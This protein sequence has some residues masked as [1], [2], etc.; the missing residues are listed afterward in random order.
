MKN[1]RANTAARRAASKRNGAQS[2]GPATLQGKFRSQTANFKH[3]LYATNN[4]RLPG[5]SV[6]EYRELQNQFLSFWMPAHPYIAGLVE[7][8]VGVQWELRRL[9]AAKHDHVLSTLGEVTQANP[10]ITDQG[11]LN[12]EAEKLASAEGGTVAKANARINALHRER[13][14]L[15]I[16]LIRLEKRPCTSGRSQMSLIINNRQ[17]SSVP[18]SED[19]KPVPGVQSEHP[20]ITEAPAEPLP[21]TLGPPVPEQTT[22]EP[23]PEPAADIV[24]WASTELNIQPD[25]VQAQIMTEQNTRVMVLAPRQTGKSTAAAV[26]VIYEAVHHHDAAI[27]IASASGRQSGQIMEKARRMAHILDLELLPPPSKCD[28]FSLANGAQVIALPDNPETIRGFSAPRLI[29]VDEA[30]FASEEL[31]KSLEPMLTVSNGT[32]ML[33]ST[34]NGQS[35]YF[36]DQWHTAASPWTRIFGTLKDCPRVNHDAIANIRKTMSEADFQQEFECKFVAASGQFISNELFE[37]C[38]RDDVEIFNMDF[39]GELI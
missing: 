19:A 35:G 6:E 34:P 17:D 8:L 1:S 23:Q 30:A 21:E 28:G 24:N 7:E 16:E 9:R 2:S 10:A 33:L 38:L 32:L 11:K 22:D 29:V 26:R 39:D 20:Y 18:A 37:S 12:L 5:E 31:F 14:R 25:A 36:Y 3:G 13:Q 4:Y 15:E 27:L